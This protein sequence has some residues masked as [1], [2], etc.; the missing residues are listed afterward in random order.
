[1][2]SNQATSGCVK[3]MSFKNYIQNVQLNK[4]FRKLNAPNPE[5]LAEEVKYFTT[6]EA[7]KRDK[8]L[9]DYLGENGINQ[10][11]NIIYEFLF[12]SPRLSVNAKVLDVGAGTGFFTVRLYD[13]VRRR[14]PKVKFYAV[15]ATPA[16]LM[17]IEKKRISITLFVG[18]AENIKG[19][20]KEARRYFDIPYRFDAVFSTLMLHHSIQPEKVFQSIKEVLKS[21]GKAIIV[22]LCKHNFEEFKKEMGD[23]H[24]GFDLEGISEMATKHFSR[25]KIEKIGGIRCECSGRST[26]IFAAFLEK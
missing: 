21:K 25:I 20:V 2:G 8:I 15:D 3:D 13:R 10:I 6:E 26:E 5:L 24:L 7:E 18:L 14:F 19:S 9:L 23:I 17:S 22:D 11:V 12:A 1:M 4:L 16:M